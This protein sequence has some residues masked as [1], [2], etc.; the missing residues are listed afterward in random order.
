MI[1]VQPVNFAESAEFT[2]C[3]LFEKQVSGNGNKMREGESALHSRR[4][5]NGI[6]VLR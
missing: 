6:S 2:G 4:L 5:R 1:D 3:F